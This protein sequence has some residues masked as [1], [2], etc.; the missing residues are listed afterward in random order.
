MLIILAFILVII[1]AALMAFSVSNYHFG[2]YE[3]SYYVPPTTGNGIELNKEMMEKVS[4]ELG[5]ATTTPL[6]NHIVTVDGTTF[7]KLF[8][9]ANSH[10]ITVGETIPILLNNGPIS[11][12]WRTE[13]INSDKVSVNIIQRTKTDPDTYVTVKNL[14]TNAPNE[15]HFT[16]NEV[17]IDGQF[18]YNDTTKTPNSFIEIEC[19]STTSSCKA[20]ILIPLN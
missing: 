4:K 2:V 7:L 11:V 5:A 17:L 20:S 6:Q 1:S 3:P 12:F 13:D 16:W 18:Q 8:T 9:Y 15:G 14:A 19:G 10:G